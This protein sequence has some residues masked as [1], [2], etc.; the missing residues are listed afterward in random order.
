MVEDCI[1]GKIQLK[2]FILLKSDQNSQQ[3][4]FGYTKI[5]LLVAS[6]EVKLNKLILGVPYM[7]S[8]NTKMHFL[9]DT[10]KAKSILTTKRG[11][12]ACPVLLHNQKGVVLEALNEIKKG[13]ISAEFSIN[14][15]F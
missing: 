11:K 9:K 10:I 4:H 1:L 5:N 12:I 7:H 13:D 15:Y 2:M 14:K 8:T 6:N 3:L